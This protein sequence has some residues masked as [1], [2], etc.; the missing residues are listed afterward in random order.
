M[1]VVMFVGHPALQMRPR[2]FGEIA[3]QFVGGLPRVIQQVFIR[4]D[5][6]EA[7]HR[8][9]ALPRAEQFARAA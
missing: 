2:R 3:Q 9:T 1:Q 4:A 6:G 7:Q 5:V 8:H